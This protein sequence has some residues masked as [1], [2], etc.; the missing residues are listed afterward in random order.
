MTRNVDRRRLRPDRHR[1]ARGPRDRHRR[2]QRR[3]L[4]RSREG[5]RRRRLRRKQRCRARLIPAAAELGGGPVQ[6]ALTDP[7]DG[8]R[9][10][11]RRRMAAAPPPRAAAEEAG[12]RQQA[13]PPPPPLPDLRPNGRT[14]WWSTTA[15]GAS[16][17]LLRTRLGDASAGGFSRPSGSLEARF[18]LEAMVGG[19]V[20]RAEPG[21]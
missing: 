17:P 18:V 20:H 2:R 11:R 8:P 9:D 1:E 4:R 10:G 3:I 6:S 16:P 15:V 14:A 21:G 12:G 13:P 5:P 7:M 19:D